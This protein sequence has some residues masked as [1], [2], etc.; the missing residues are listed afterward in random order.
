MKHTTG[1]SLSV[2]N[3]FVLHC[4]VKENSL[5]PPPYICAHDTHPAGFGF[6]IWSRVLWDC[7]LRWCMPSRLSFLRSLVVSVGNVMIK[8]ASRMSGACD[9]PIQVYAYASLC[10]G[11]RR[12]RANCECGLALLIKRLP[13][14]WV[15]EWPWFNCRKVLQFACD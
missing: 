13:V 2:T 7:R 8:R 5:G 10:G 12:M 11:R 1:T 3:R 9:R 4:Q 15:E 14:V 6:N